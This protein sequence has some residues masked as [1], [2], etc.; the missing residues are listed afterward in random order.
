MK[1][2]LDQINQTVLHR[3]N[4]FYINYNI[5]M[6]KGNKHVLISNGDCD[7]ISS[8][9]LGIAPGRTSQML[10]YSDIA[11]VS[12]KSGSLNSHNVGGN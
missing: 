9:E 11:T 7:E 3:V 4:I 12:G 8:F 2:Y 6:V 5:A 10:S 1:V